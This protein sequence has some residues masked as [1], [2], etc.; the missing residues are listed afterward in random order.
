MTPAPAEV[1]TTPHGSLRAELR[2]V[3]PT[4]TPADALP[5]KVV[6]PSC[7]YS[8]TLSASYWLSMQETDD[9]IVQNAIVTDPC[10]WTPELPFLYELQGDSSESPKTIGLRD[11]RSQGHAL[12]LDGQNLVLRGVPVGDEQLTNADWQA[13]RDLQLALVVTDPSIEFCWSAARQGVPLV[14]MVEEGPD[15]TDA[16]PHGP[17]SHDLDD[18]LRQL[19]ICPGVLIVLL[20]VDALQAAIDPLPGGPLYG[21]AICDEVVAPPDWARCMGVV[22]EESKLA[23]VANER[24]NW[25]LLVF[26][27]GDGFDTWQE[28]R[29]AC[30][31][32]QADCAPLTNLA[33]YFVV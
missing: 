20:G 26:R 18:T 24:P 33:G 14:V 15:L 30:E 11:W 7:A 21:I 10:Y 31:Q 32:L 5:K 13:L 19:A 8:Q 17:G 9:A 16:Q 6:G 25:P 4:G 2:I 22:I 12:R 23:E 28:A 29:R 1:R 3:W 27:H